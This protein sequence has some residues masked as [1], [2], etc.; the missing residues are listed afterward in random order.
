VA[1]VL[2]ND[3]RLGAAGTIADGYVTDAKVAANANIQQSKIAG[4]T[5]SL[6]GKLSTTG[7]TLTGSLSGTGA[8]FTGTVNVDTL[9]VTGGNFIASGIRSQTPPVTFPGVYLGQDGVGSNVGIEI[10]TLNT[11]GSSY[12]D[13][14]RC[15]ANNNARII[16]NNSTGALTVTA[17]SIA[18]GTA[19]ACSSTLTATGAVTLSS[20]LA[21]GASTL[22]SLAVTGA[23]TL[24]TLTAAGAVTCNGGLVVATN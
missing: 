6:A 7:G 13:F 20:T 11:S 12:I 16:C 4:L 18:L 15:G 3:S 8:T 14:T 9:N 2:D 24:S 21:A 1:V 17:G 10:A 22:A 5:T 19:T 23:T